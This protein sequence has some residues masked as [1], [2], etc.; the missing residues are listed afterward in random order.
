[1]SAREIFE[2]DP[3]T[4]HVPG[5]RREGSDPYKLQR[6]LAKHGTS[7]AGMPPIE[8]SRGTDGELVINDGVTRATRAAKFLPGTLVPVEVIDTLA[9]PG[10]QFPTIGDLL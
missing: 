7:I 9:I 2:I 3:A 8:V 10:G 5:T 4:F 1:M 6:Q